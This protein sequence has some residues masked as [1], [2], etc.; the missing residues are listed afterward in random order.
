MDSVK[1]K[2][3]ISGLVDRKMDGIESQVNEQKELFKNVADVLDEVCLTAGVKI[4]KIPGK[5]K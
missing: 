1:L 2:E 3:F 4:S 5:I